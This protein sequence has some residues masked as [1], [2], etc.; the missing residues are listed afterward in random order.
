MSFSS[1]AHLGQKITRNAARKYNTQNCSQDP[2][3]THTH[4]HMQAHSH[5]KKHTHTHTHVRTHTCMSIRTYDHTHIQSHTHTHTHTCTSTRIQHRMYF[6]CG[7]HSFLGIFSFG[8]FGGPVRTEFLLLL[9]YFLQQPRSLWFHTLRRP[10]FFQ[11]LYS[12]KVL[13]LF[14]R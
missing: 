3:L 10:L 7:T 9:C 6:Y 11:V 13:M 12:T 8:G 4:I 14:G 2:T 5:V 1:S